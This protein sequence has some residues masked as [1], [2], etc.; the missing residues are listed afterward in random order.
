MLAAAGEMA[1]A[2]EPARALAGPTRLTT[3]QRWA[4]IALHEAGW[5]EQEN[6][7]SSR[8]QPEDSIGCCCSL[9]C[10]WLFLS[11]ARAA[12][13]PRITTIEED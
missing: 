13:R 1:A 10:V 3:E 8:V 2:A 4:I 11:Q 5:G 6:C 9:H 7:T 12:G